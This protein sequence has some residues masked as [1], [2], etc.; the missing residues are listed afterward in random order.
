MIVFPY[1]DIWK[2]INYFNR[3]IYQK[4]TVIMYIQ[5]IEHEAP[6]S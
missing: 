5:K 2:T 3:V 6:V 4:V 1:L